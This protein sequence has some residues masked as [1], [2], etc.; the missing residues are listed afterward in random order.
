MINEEVSSGLDII[1]EWEIHEKDEEGR[2]NKK[3]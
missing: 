2:K 3:E 1:L